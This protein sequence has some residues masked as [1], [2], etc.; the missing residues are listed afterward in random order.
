MTMMMVNRTMRSHLLVQLSHK[1]TQ[2]ALTVPLQDLMTTFLTKLGTS[3]SKDGEWCNNVQYYKYVANL[4]IL[5]NAWHVC[6]VRMHD[7]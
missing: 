1:D 2:A 5:I 3:S 7:Y 6:T 4:K